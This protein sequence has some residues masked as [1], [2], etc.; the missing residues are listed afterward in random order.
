VP[1]LA[2]IPLGIR[3][4]RFVSPF[5]FDWIIRLTL[6]VMASRL[7]YGAWIASG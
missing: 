3:A 6:V 2:C 7:L 1:A 5:W 4:R